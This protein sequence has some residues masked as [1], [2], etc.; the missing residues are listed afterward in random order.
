MMFCIN[1]GQQEKYAVD[2]NDCILLCHKNIKQSFS[3]TVSLYSY[4]ELSCE[5][6]YF[7]EYFQFH[8]ALLT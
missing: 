5:C 7:F 1:T 3:S 6:Y 8:N 4:V 2:H